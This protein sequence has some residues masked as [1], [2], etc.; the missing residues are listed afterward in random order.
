MDIALLA[1]GTYPYHPGGVSVWCDQLVRGL[2]PHRFSLHSITGTDN[3]EPTWELPDNVT[4]LHPIA[5]WGSARL[6]PRSVR[7]SAALRSV[8]EQLAVSIVEADGRELFLD[9]LHQLFDLSQQT[10]MVG[11]LRCDQTLQVLLDAMRGAATTDRGVDAPPV[12]VTVADATVVL[13]LIEHQLRP[14]FAAPPEADLC[15]ATSNGLSILP[16]LGAHW[17]RQTPLVLS[18]HGIY[19]RER[20]LAYGP[21][22]YPHAVRSFMLRFFKRIT[23][24]GYEIAS[25]IAPGSEYNRY[26]QT[27]NGA[28]AERIHPIYNGVDA[29]DFL[30]CPSEPDVPTLVWLGRIDPLKDVETLLRSFQLVHRALPAARLRIF[31]AASAENQ[32]YLDRCVSLRDALDLAGSATFE[33]RADSVVDA[34]H[35]G[36]IVLLTSISEGFPYTLIEAMASGMPTIATDVGGVRE[37]SGDAG[38]IVPPQNPEATAEACLQLLGDARL[39]R[40]IGHAARN[41]ILSMFTLEQSLAIF[42]DLYR[43]VT[44]RITSAPVLERD[45]DRSRQQV[46]ARPAPAARRVSDTPIGNPPPRRT[47]LPIGAA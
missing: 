16:A 36:H 18:E 10:P 42:G 2:A 27:A 11:A 4:G 29:S 5:L 43:E 15:H 41:R 23:W 45:Q 19:L 25:A 40:T 39:R 47:L 26:W 8:V 35:A 1:E 46:D 20:Y 32:S 30:T 33:G 17:A 14:L 37:A 3:D 28:A 21:G 7:K 38:L 34:Y 44:G 6:A 9:A 13:N 31:G 22:A 24:A 12:P